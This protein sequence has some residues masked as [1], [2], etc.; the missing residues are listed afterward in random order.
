M[1]N[2]PDFISDLILVPPYHYHYNFYTLI[3]AAAV[4]VSCQQQGITS[5]LRE[6]NS[7]CPGEQVNF[8]CTLRGSLALAWIS[9][10]YIADDN[11][12]QFSIASTLGV[13]VL[14]M[15]NGR[16]TATARLTTNSMDNGE[17]VLQSTLRITATEASMVTCSGTNG[18][19]ESTFFISGTYNCV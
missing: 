6:G 18:D 5:T 10:G 11:P 9:P 17:Q 16:I 8:T 3:L 15:I 1:F 19:I 13:D 4:Y 14:S 12:L 2:E 7:T